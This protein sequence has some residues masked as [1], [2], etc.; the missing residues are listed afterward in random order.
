MPVVGS[1]LV[2]ARLND[3][4]TMKPASLRGAVKLWP[5]GVV[6]LLRVLWLMYCQNGAVSLSNH[7]F[8]DAS[9]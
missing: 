2:E 3:G 6:K 5:L 1:L 9:H 8:S 4:D 7:V